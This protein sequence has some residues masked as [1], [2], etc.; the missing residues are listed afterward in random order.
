[1]TSSDRSSIGWIGLGN[2]GSR[3]APRLLGAGRAL[4]AFDRHE[5]RVASLAAAGAL[6]ARSVAEVG[7]RCAVVFCS[8]PDGE[9]LAE[10]ATGPDGLISRMRPGA[11]LIDTSTVSAA[12]SAHVAARLAGRGVA[13]LRAPVSGS[14]GPAGEGRLSFFVSGPPHALAEHRA[15]LDRLGTKLVYLGSG[16]EARVMKLVVNVVVAITNG[17]LAE[18]LD[19]G[20]RSGLDWSAMLDGIADSVAASPYVLSKLDTLKR[21]DWT[22]AGPV[23]VIAKDLDYV[24]EAG[25]TCGSY[26]PLAALARQSLA[27]LEGRGAGNLDLAAVLTLLEEPRPSA[28]SHGGASP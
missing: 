2:M 12:A 4:V 24:L 6:T 23:W 3:M 25:R 1:M 9:V 10:V 21:R 17:G 22:A 19:F 28:V 27:A 11:C 20:R 8:L 13:F 26:M 7:E 18:A 16:E 5:D 14:T 15:L